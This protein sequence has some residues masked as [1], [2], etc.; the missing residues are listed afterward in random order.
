MQPDKNEIERI[1]D[2][3]LI[4]DLN[5]GDIT[6]TITIPVGT[7]TQFLI[8][9]REEMVVCGI[10]IAAC[11]FSKIKSE[12][13]IIVRNKIKDGQIAN[14][15][16]IMLEGSGDARAIMAAERVALNILRQMCGVAT[17]TKQFADK[18]KH[19]K[20]KL[21]DTRKTIPG[22]RSLQKYAVK[23]GG[24][25]NH[26]F[27]L[28]DGILIK[29]NHIAICGGIENALK[30]AQTQA[31]EGFK[32]EIECDTLEQLKDALKFG[33]DIVLLDNMSINEL[34][35]A[36]KIVNGQIPLEASGGVNL[37]TICKIAETGVDFISVGS[38]T[39]NPANV[40]IGLDME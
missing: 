26:R 36:V 40:D 34:L 25:Y 12:G 1:I 6:S 18:I 31:P 22:L 2:A 3:A 39:N 9:A 15:G 38:I 10:D 4:E 17:V 30:I 24:G 37:D 27:G 21:L 33:A 29:D 32:I 28:Y 7:S 14:A 8:R 11:V 16:D 13:K 23:T 20:A 35:E 5:T 19:T